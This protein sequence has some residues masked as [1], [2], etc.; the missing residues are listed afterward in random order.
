VFGTP[1]QARGREQ[2][3]S[4]GFRTRIL[5]VPAQRNETETELFEWLNLPRLITTIQSLIVH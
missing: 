1:R 3:I 5:D 4:A 2:K